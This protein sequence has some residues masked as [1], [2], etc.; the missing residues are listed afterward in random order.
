MK[1][2][3]RNFTH[4]L[5]ALLVCL[6]LGCTNPEWVSQ[7]SETTN[8]LYDVF[9]PDADTG[10]IIGGNLIFEYQEGTILRTTNG[11]ETWEEQEIPVED[12]LRNVF[13]YRC[14]N[15]R[16]LDV[17]VPSCI[18]RRVASPSKILII[19]SNSAFLC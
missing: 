18:K 17:M 13:F 6:S 16:S 7:I 4:L 12:A 8:D 3:I 9:S 5:S 2:I 19:L 1:R 10:T 11:V 14:I 15:R